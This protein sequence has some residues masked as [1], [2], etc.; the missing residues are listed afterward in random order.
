MAAAERPRMRIDQRQP[1][2]PWKTGLL[3]AERIETYRKAIEPLQEAI[4]ATKAARQSIF[5]WVKASAWAREA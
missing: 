1:T 5:K 4:A 2:T 3:T